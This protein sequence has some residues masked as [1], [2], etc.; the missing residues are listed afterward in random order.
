MSKRPNA[1]PSPAR[2]QQSENANVPTTSRRDHTVSKE[3]GRVLADHRTASLSARS[4]SR[5]STGNRRVMFGKSRFSLDWVK[6]S[7]M[8]ANRLYNGYTYRSAVNL[9]CGG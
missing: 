9:G 4:D 5:A 3:L 2:A 7:A 6:S 8:L 1:I